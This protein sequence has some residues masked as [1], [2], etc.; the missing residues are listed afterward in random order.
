MHKYIS[1]IISI[2]IIS[3]A[4]YMVMHKKQQKRKER[5]KIDSIG[6]I[7]KSDQCGQEGEFFIEKGIMHPV[8][9]DLSQKRYKGIVLYHGLDQ[10]YHPKSWER[11][12]YFS[13]YTVDNKGNL[14][15]IP[16]PFISIRPVTFDLLKNLY[17]IDTNTGKLSI[18]MHFDDIKP[19]STNPFGLNAIAY[20]CDNGTLWISAIDESDYQTQK[21]VIY[22]IDPKNKKILARFEG[23]DAFSLAVVKTNKGKFLFLGSAKD[24]GLY[25]MKITKNNLIMSK[26][27]K[28]FDLSN[29]EE[30]IRKI[31]VKEKNRLEIQTIP[32]TYTLITES[33]KKERNYYDVYYDEIDDTWDIL[34]KI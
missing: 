33:G 10:I 28:L 2:F 8:T 11:F 31:K 13:T 23:W 1:I 9:I 24:S 7:H 27:V 22:H 19:S 14:Y 34:K 30:H 21:G 12:E 5:I 20:D 29:P 4:G 15:L 25:A 26:P 3:V 17:R 6:M 16:M 32:F 18:F